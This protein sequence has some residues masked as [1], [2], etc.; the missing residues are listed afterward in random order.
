MNLEGKNHLAFIDVL[1]SCCGVVFTVEEE[2]LRESRVEVLSGQTASLTDRRRS[3]LLACLQDSMSF[4]LE[5]E[6][7]PGS[8]QGVSVSRRLPAPL[9]T[10]LSGLLADVITPASNTLSSSSSEM[11][12]WILVIHESGG[13]S[14]LTQRS[15]LGARPHT[16]GI[17][18]A[19]SSQPRPRPPHLHHAQH[20]GLVRLHRPEEFDP[21]SDHTPDAEVAIGVTGPHHSAA[22]LSCSTHLSPPA[23]PASTAHFTAPAPDAHDCLFPCVSQTYSCH[24]ACAH[25]R[26]GQPAQTRSCAL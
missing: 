13:R 14:Y 2:T 15:V 4:L 26:R 9:L 24:L 8:C 18:R 21:V 16:D 10:T 3:R 5:V 25:G 23:H 11:L 20:R 7:K 12:H 17:L 6:L 1:E 22:V 19:V